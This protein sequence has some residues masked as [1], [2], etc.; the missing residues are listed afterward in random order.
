MAR[1][2]EISQETV[3]L[4]IQSY[5]EFDLDSTLFAG[6]LR[7]LSSS[8]SPKLSY[9]K[10]NQENLLNSGNKLKQ[11]SFDDILN[12]HRNVTTCGKCLKY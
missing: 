7:Y 10:L 8:S 12:I 11:C 2:D 3:C 1:C 6:L 9:A 5:S 4:G